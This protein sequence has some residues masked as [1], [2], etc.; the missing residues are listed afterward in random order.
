MQKVAAGVLTVVNIKTNETKAA[1]PSSEARKSINLHLGTKPFVDLFC[2]FLECVSNSDSCNGS[3]TEN[4]FKRSY[5]LVFKFSWTY[6][7]KI[8]F[9]IKPLA[10]LGSGLIFNSI[11]YPQEEK[12][13][14]LVRKHNETVNIRAYNNFV[15]IRQDS[16][17]VSKLLR[18]RDVTD[19]G[20]LFKR[21][22]KIFC[23]TSG[24]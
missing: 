10:L 22:N 2:N 19:R 9:R 21:F 23:N 17:S 14:R 24:A 8:A 20:I 1:R 18:R 13:L 11:V 15:F 4:N 12:F 6:T 16:C 5:I 7:K 3:R